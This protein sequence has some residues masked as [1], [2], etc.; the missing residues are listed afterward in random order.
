MV[1]VSLKSSWGDK[2]QKGKIR[3][4]DNRKL[5]QWH[6]FLSFFHVFITEA[7][8]G[9]KKYKKEQSIIQFQDKST[10]NI[11]FKC[12]YTYVCV[13][14]VAQLC[15]TLCNS[16]DCR[17]PGSPVHVIFQQ[18]YWTG[19]PLSSPGDLPHPGIKPASLASPAL[20][21]RF[22]TIPAHLKKIVGK[23]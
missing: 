16:T 14:A 18:E 7:I 19:L 20:A 12:W 17:P 6:W 11:I 21:G 5:S 10:I 23:V 9:Q 13:R 1:R 15:P 3:G 2:G 8:Q 22:F 4:N